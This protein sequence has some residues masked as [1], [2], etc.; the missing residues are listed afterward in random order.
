VK[1]LITMLL[2]AVA[3]AA[4][5]Q[6]ITGAGATFPAPLYSKWASEY[7]KST[8]VKINYQ[9]VGSGAGIKQI[10]A[11]TVVFGA[12]DMPLT[13][14]K[15]KEIGLF[16]FPTVIGGVVPVINVKG[17]EPGQLRLTGTLLADIFLG[18]I[19][20]WDDAA[21]KALNPALVLPDQAI[22]VVRRADGS[23]TTFIWTNYLSKV[24]RE[25]KETIGEGTAVNWKVGAGG[26][27]NEGVAAMVRQ[28]PGTLGYVEFAYVKQNKMAWVNVQNSAG[29]WVAPTE[30]AFRAAAANADWNKSYYQILTN[31]AGK[32][33]W[34]ITGATFILVYIKPEDVAKSK[35]AMTFFDWAFANGD[36]AADDLDYVSLPLA[37]KNKIRA[38]WKHLGLF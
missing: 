7:N 31:Q 8:G 2:A 24:S 19:T 17:I 32:E 30:D 25:F 3:F 14:E 12:S 27:G 21:I 33:A 11:K 13:D 4:T 22:T 37:V 29:T 6:D 35:S 38:D 10:E 23:G 15:L 20:K 26:K 9:S 28:L 1:K 18:K 34:P 36:K 5:A 16:Q